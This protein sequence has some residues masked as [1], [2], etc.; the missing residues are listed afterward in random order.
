MG[1]GRG[2]ISAEKRSPPGKSW[3]A[4]TVRTWRAGQGREG[5]STL[6]DWMD[7]RISANR[8]AR[9]MARLTQIAVLPK[10]STA[11]RMEQAG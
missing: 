9:A 4:R 6:T 2:L 7:L 1:W 11:G 8:S 10:C 5:G 3:A